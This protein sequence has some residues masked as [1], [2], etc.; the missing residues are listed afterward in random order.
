MSIRY[1]ITN[2]R[3]TLSWLMII[4]CVL[5]IIYAVYEFREKQKHDGIPNLLINIASYITTTIALFITLIF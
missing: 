5:I 4:I 1:L 2:N 3:Y